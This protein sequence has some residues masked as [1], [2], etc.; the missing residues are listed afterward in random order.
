MLKKSLIIICI[1]IFISLISFVKA[2]EIIYGNLWVEYNVTIYGEFIGKRAL[3]STCSNNQLLIFN[4]T[5]DTWVCASQSTITVTDVWVNIT[6]N[7]TITGNINMSGNSLTDVGELIVNTLSLKGN[8]TPYTDNLYNLGSQTNWFKNL[9]AKN[10]YT[11]MLNATTVNTTELYASN[12]DANTG[13]VDNLSSK[14]IT[15]GPNRVMN[16]SGDMVVVLQ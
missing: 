7:E 13:D 16:L 5:S 6:G 14:Q 8:A 12:I 10:I 9:W 11:D 15:I 2:D 4:N 3:P 1:A